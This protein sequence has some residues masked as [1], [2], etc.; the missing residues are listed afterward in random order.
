[1]TCTNFKFDT[2]LIRAEEITKIKVEHNRHL[3]IGL[4]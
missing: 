2:R 1:M 3:P 4:I